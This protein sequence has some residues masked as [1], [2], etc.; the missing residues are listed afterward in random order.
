MV[1]GSSDRD[2]DGTAA[3][4]DLATMT[5]LEE[6]GRPRRRRSLLTA[7]SALLC[8]AALIAIA[9]IT[10]ATDEDRS[11]PRVD[12]VDKKE[13]VDSP[14]AQ[15]V[16]AAVG[17]TIATGS[18]TASY[19]THSI[20]AS[21]G[22]E[23]ACGAAVPP[24]DPDASVGCLDVA[25]QAVDITGVATINTAPY[26]MEATSQVTGFG[27]IV[28]HVDGTRLWEKGGGNYGYNNPY[29]SVGGPGDSISGFASLV[30]G[31]GGGRAP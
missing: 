12:Q 31:T 6:M 21:P 20:P 15:Q 13:V 14:E 2:R 30:S 11:K 26:R 19:E 9:V 23:Q 29:G 5:D 4:N 16:F 27:T 3:P 17:E 25:H 7:F 10:T 22:E 1:D 24:P 8:V 18:Y 28:I